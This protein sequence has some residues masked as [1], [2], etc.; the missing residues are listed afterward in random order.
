MVNND[1]NK[2]HR[3]IITDDPFVCKRIG[4]TVL[5]SDEW[6]TIK[7]TSMRDIMKLKFEQNPHLID[8]LI[9]TGDR[10]LQEAT[11]DATWG[12]GAGIRSKAAKE[13]TAKGTNLLGNILMQLRLKLGAKRS[14]A[15]SGL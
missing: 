3:I 4:G 11:T 2:A 6:D 12:I 8:M 1:L 13:N 15:E 9:A 14:I 10:I 7:E 5:E